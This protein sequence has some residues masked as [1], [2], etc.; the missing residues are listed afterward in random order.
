MG[1]AIA[2][3][4]YSLCKKQMAQKH[5]ILNAVK[6]LV[7]QCKSSL[8]ATARFF[9]VASDDMIYQMRLFLSRPLQ[10]MPM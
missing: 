1:F 10:L 5:V 2:L 6:D 7:L 8:R 4:R 9:G 3:R